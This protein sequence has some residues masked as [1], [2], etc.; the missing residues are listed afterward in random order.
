MAIGHF[1]DGASTCVVG[2]HTHVPTADTRILDKGT[3]YQTDIG[4]C[5]DYNSVIGMNK[6]NSLK[7]FFKDKEAIKHFPSEG[8]GTLSG[9][10]VEADEN[11]GLAKKVLRIISGGVLTK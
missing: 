9:V 2:T 11:T 8:D 5:G 10:I 6:D 1:F 4:M 3:A 7:K